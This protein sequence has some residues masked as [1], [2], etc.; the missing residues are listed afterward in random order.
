MIPFLRQVASRLPEGS[1][2]AAELAAV[3]ASGSSSRPHTDVAV[4]ALPEIKFPRNGRG[5]RKEREE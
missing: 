3:V 4:D 5:S 1:V 2:V